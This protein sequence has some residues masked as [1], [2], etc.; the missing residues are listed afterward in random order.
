MGAAIANDFVWKEPREQSESDNV[1]HS[2]LSD[3]L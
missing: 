3:S 2:I 1:S